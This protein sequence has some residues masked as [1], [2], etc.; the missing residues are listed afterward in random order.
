MVNQ[1]DVRSSVIDAVEAAAW[2]QLDVA[3]YLR[4]PKTAATNDRMGRDV[5]RRKIT[6]QLANQE[7]VGDPLKIV[8]RLRKLMEP[9]P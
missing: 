2:L 8:S 6:R 5:L 3:D 4:L 1:I 9:A 7:A